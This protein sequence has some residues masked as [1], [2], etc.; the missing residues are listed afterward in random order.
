MGASP[1]HHGDR[2]EHQGGEDRRAHHAL[3]N[4]LNPCVTTLYPSLGNGN[5]E[6]SLPSPFIDFSSLPFRAGHEAWQELAPS[7]PSIDGE[8]TE[9]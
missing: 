4:A 8:E 2:S 9:F 1:C 3:K 6:G 5:G 7:I